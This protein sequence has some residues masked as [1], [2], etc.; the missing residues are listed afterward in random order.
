MKFGNR[1]HDSEDAGGKWEEGGRGSEI[2]MAALGKRL[3][4]RLEMTDLM[5]LET[6]CSTQSFRMWQVGQIKLLVLSEMMFVFMTDVDDSPS[7]AKE[8]K[9]GQRL[10]CLCDGDRFE[11]CPP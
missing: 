9:I 8:N 7:L 3:L 1:D 5:E 2:R 4:K 10:V 11:V 6:F